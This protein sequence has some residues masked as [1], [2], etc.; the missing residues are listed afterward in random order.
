MSD[1][2]GVSGPAGGAPQPSRPPG[3]MPAVRGVLVALGGLYLATD[4]LAVM[5]VGAVVAT[6]VVG[7]YVIM[8]RS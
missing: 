5:I 3:M 4:S 2:A 1:V 7:V 8:H 6:V